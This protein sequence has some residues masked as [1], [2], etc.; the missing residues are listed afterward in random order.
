MVE[1]VWTDEARSWLREIFDYVA[2]SSPASAA[3][4][5]DG[6]LD[7]VER[8]RSFPESGS[9]IET[10]AL[11]ELRMVLYGHYR[12]VYRSSAGH[13]EV[14]GVFHGAL[15]LEQRLSSEVPPGSTTIHE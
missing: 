6:I 8:L 4:V 2:S 1:V 15:D 10:P 3:R 14:I 11:S 13:I 5:V 9:R 12:I 7:R